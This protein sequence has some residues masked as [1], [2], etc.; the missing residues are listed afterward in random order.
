MEK[1]FGMREVGALGCQREFNG[2]C[3]CKAYYAIVL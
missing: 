1:L 2:E 3:S